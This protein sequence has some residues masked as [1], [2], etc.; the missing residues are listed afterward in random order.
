[1]AD[2]SPVLMTRDELNKCCEQNIPIGTFT[3]LNGDPAIMD[4]WYL[5][6]MDGKYFRTRYDYLGKDKIS[7]DPVEMKDGNEFYVLGQLRK[8][9][10]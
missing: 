10:L 7:G 8:L 5:R 4:T 2:E 3:G 1:M 9:Q 6:S